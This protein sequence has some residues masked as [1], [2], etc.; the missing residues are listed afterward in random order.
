MGR[1]GLKLSELCLGTL[2]FGW[3]T[4]E[5]TAFAVLY[6]YNAAGGNFLPATSYGAVQQC[7]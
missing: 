3:K 4:D 5:K 6:A 2:N 7:L 1:T